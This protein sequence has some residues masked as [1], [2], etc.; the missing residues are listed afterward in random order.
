MS[1]PRGSSTV[2]M[3]VLA[4]VLVLVLVFTVGCGRWVQ[5]TI[6]A[7]NAA[8]QAARAASLVSAARMEHVALGQV[9]LHIEQASSDCGRPSADVRLER[10]G[11]TSSVHVS[12]R[13][14]VNMRG[15]MSLFGLPRWVSAS[16]S[17]VIDV[18]TFR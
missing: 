15:L 17:E 5:A 14:R 13:C 4:P 6:A 1:P 7:R 2:E 9:A 16:S 3:V 10:A 11:R 12:V 8:D 18:F